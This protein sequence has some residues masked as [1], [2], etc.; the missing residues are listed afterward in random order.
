MPDSTLVL[1]RLTCLWLF[2]RHLSQK[3]SFKNVEILLCATAKAKEKDKGPWFIWERTFFTGYT[4]QLRKRGPSQDPHSE[5]SHSH[6]FSLPL[7]KNSLVLFLDTS[8]LSTG[9]AV[10]IW[11]SQRSL[12]EPWVSLRAGKRDKTIPD[13]YDQLHRGL[14]GNVFQLKRENC[15]EGHR[16]LYLQTW[17]PQR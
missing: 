1:C 8:S 2:I 10:Y 5:V 4:D 3:L 16:L 6:G 17:D 13:C 15:Y 9:C 11:E 12:C 7:W 14:S